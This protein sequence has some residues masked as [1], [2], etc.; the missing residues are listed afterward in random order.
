MLVLDASSLGCAVKKGKW[1]EFACVA[2]HPCYV[3]SMIFSDF[4]TSALRHNQAVVIKSKN[5]VSQY[6]DAM[7]LKYLYRHLAA[8]I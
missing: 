6:C 7:T 3:S 2:F 8:N 5:R 4:E 1:D